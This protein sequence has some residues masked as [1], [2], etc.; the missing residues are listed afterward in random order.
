M[1]RSGFSTAPRFSPDP[2]LAESLGRPA[3]RLASEG[4]GGRD[5]TLALEMAGL[6]GSGDAF[7][8]AKLPTSGV[9]ECIALADAGFA[10]IDTAITLSSSGSTQT[11]AGD[12]DVG[13][14]SHDQYEAIPKIAETCFRLSR[15]H[16]DP[17]IPVSAANSIKRR[18]LESYVQGT[19]G[20][21]LYAAARDGQVAGFLAVID[22]SVKGRPT[23]VIDLLGVAEEHQRRGAGA[24]LVRHFVND[25]RGRASELRVGTQAAN[26]RS[27]RLYENSGFRIVESNYVLHAHYRHGEILR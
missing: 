17:K 27:L 14:A 16:L 1:V 10:V 4:V 25:W 6:A 3:F 20:S 5:G 18:W 9:Q 22:Y 12:Y 8:Y 7:F 15:F 13:I 24:A 2:W 11:A 23:A 21:T 19:R 26:I